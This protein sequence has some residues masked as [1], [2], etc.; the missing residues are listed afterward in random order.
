MPFKLQL[1]WT[2]TSSEQS[3]NEQ[4]LIDMAKAITGDQLNVGDMPPPK[5]F[6]E[7]GASGTAVFG[8]YVVN[9]ETNPKLASK[10][11]RYR[12][13]A[14]M[15]A[16]IS[17]IAAGVRYFMNLVSKPAW[18]VMPVD[19]SDEAKLYAEFVQDVMCKCKTSW[20]RIVRRCASYR[21]HGFSINEWIAIKRD[22]GLIGF[23][24]IEP[25][26]QHSIERWDVSEKGEILGVFQRPPQTGEE[27]GIPRAKF[28][29]MVDDMMTDSPEGM[30]WFRALV[31][32]AERMKSYLSLETI[33][34]ERD[35]SGTPVGRAP[36]SL[37]NKLVAEKKITATEGERMINGMRKF[38]QLEVKRKNTGMLIDSKHYVDTAADGTKT[39][40]VPQWGIELLTGTPTSMTA[41]GA[42]IERLTKDMARIMGVESILV[43][44]EG[45][46]S[47]ALSKDKSNN[48]Y[49]QV[50]STLIDMAGFM[51]K[52]FLDTLWM[53]NG[54][55][56]EM[57]PTM[58]TE[59]V[60]F[61]DVEAI[62]TALK[63]LA[64]AGA[65]LMADDPVIN[66]IRDLLGV[67]RADLEQALMQA[68]VNRATETDDPE[69]PN[70]PNKEEGEQEEEEEEGAQ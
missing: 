37:I 33:G 15:L 18:T 9:E 21:W 1:P 6:D 63:D 19:D 49:L 24:D 68:M 25:R 53:L 10:E 30:G 50:N 38:V 14:D 23:L 45:V 36:I 2:W 5:P 43:G 20:P 69:N 40:S 22:D 3:I 47:L 60:A 12:T 28:I 39:T 56:D 48:L 66:D 13:A 46:G 8:G 35:L 26:P 65:P 4:Q 32:P 67:S 55:P 61:K 16:N 54:F 58:K 31:E 7:M 29:Y 27:L 51:N 52:D 64:T 17:I 57:K 34:F 41:L 70:D 62:T 44:S 42:A 11:M 59:D